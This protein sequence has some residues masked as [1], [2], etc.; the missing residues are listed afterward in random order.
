MKRLHVHV[1]VENLPKTLAFYSIL[2]GREPDV[3]K[4]DYAKWQLED[5]RV[6]FAIS[7]RCGSPGVDHL[8]I[9]VETDD[10]LTE[11]DAR[12]TEADRTTIAQENVT[13]CYAR[14]NKR[15]VADP[16]GVAWE[17]FRTFGDAEVYGDD[18]SPLDTTDAEKSEPRGEISCCA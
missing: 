4:D 7:K 9:Q 14:G 13:C 1:N 8:G 3:H 10:D 5:P 6:N 2:F 15:W 17:A 16:Q 12:L 11:L 18:H